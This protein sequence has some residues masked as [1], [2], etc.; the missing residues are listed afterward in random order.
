MERD[1]MILN[2]S[3]NLSTF[4][5]KASFFPETFA[6]TYYLQKSYVRKMVVIGQRRIENLENK[7][8][9][10]EFSYSK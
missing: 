3:Y 2:S 6:T 5:I 4:K 10:E 7:L 1:V 8:I 9:F